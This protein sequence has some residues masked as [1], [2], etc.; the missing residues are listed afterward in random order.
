MIGVQLPVS[1]H[2]Q[3]YECA[4]PH[5]STS[6]K[7]PA[8]HQLIPGNL[9]FKNPTS[10]ISKSDAKPSR[11]DEDPKSIDTRRLDEY[12]AQL[13]RISRRMVCTFAFFIVK[14]PVLIESIG[15]T[16]RFTAA[17]VCQPST[18]RVHLRALQEEI[19]GACTG[20]STS[21]L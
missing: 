15:R 6:M 20:C 17:K 11:T 9:A 3:S 13:L 5:T 8:E 10:R 19:C 4:V 16:S 1:S 14:Y 2:V 18:F 21:S 7:L 12:T